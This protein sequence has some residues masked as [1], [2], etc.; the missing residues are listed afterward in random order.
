MVASCHLFTQGSILGKK[1][2]QKFHL[3]AV[4]ILVFFQE[5]KNFQVVLIY[6]FIS[7]DNF[8]EFHLKLPKIV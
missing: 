4:R 2:F 5:G 3:P 6:F 1:I 8:P 7:F